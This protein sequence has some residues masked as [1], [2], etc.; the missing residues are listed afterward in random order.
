MSA[1]AIGTGVVYVG[2][3]KHRVWA[4][5][6][7]GLK[8]PDQHCR[9]T[10]RDGRNFWFCDDDRSFDDATKRC[11][12]AGMRLLKVETK[13]DE[14]FV[15]SHSHHRCWIGRHDSDHDAD[16]SHHD[17]HHD[18]DGCMSFA[19]HDHAKHGEHCDSAVN[20]YACE[21]IPPIIDTPDPHEHDDHHGGGSSRCGVTVPGGGSNAGWLWACVLPLVVA[22]MRRRRHWCER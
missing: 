2:T 15:S 7:E 19:G 13:E 12:D 10:T 20:S 21:G 16:D 14:D 3:E 22:V 1:P 9:F 11:K 6:D 4:I 17:T 5:S 18:D 8:S